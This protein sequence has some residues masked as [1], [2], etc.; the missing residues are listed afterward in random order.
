MYRLFYI[1]ILLPIISFSQS[2][3]EL[4][5]IINGLSSSAQQMEKENIRLSNKA[6]AQ[7]IELNDVRRKLY[8][9]EK[10]VNNRIIQK[11][12]L[13]EIRL[14]LEKTKKQYRIKEQELMR[15]LQDEIN[16]NS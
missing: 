6:H 10:E 13:K 14:E 1:I 2:K 11:E 5:T 7:L 8:A 16:K 3:R 12:K 4:Q 15:K 9:A